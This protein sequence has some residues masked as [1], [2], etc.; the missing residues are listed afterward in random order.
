M[1]ASIIHVVFTSFRLVEKCD[2]ILND[3]EQ[4]NGHYFAL[5]H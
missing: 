3:R 1:Q 2:V 4:C 5:L